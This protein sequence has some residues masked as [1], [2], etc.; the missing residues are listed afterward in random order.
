M[1]LES[2]L[3]A[4]RIAVMCGFGSASYFNTFFRR[5]ARLTP[6]Q[7]RNSQRVGK[8]GRRKGRPAR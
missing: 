1:L 4:A 8:R 2:D 3:S 7:F 5:L 6:L